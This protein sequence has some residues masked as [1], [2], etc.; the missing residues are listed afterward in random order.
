MRPKHSTEG[1][2]GAQDTEDRRH[3]NSKV[4]KEEPKAEDDG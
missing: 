2:T 1:V 3:G 4:A